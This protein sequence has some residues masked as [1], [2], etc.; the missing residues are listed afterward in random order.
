MNKLFRRGLMLAAAIFSFGIATAQLPQQMPALPVDTAVHVGKLDNGL[1][2][3]IR[4]NNTPKGQVD[5]FIAQKV[6]SILEE[7]NQRGLA[8]FL[9]HMC[10]NGSEN[11]PGNS[12]INWLESVGVKFGHNLNAYTDVDE[13][14]YRI[15]NVPAS[16]K[17]VIDSCLLVLH[18]W[19]CALT[20]DPKEIDS[21]RKVI[22]EEWRQAM[23]GEMRVIEKLLPTIYPDN[24][25][26]ERLP[27]GTMG[28]VDNFPYQAL[29]DYYHTWYRPDQQ[30]IIVVGDIDPTYVEAKIK[31]Y[32][33]PIKMPENAKE[34]VYVPVDDNPG[35]IYAV[36]S[37]PEVRSAEFSISFKTDPMLPKE[38]RNTQAFFPVEYMKS[39]VS[40]ML[41]SRL[42]EL[43]KSPDC[44]FARASVSLGK[45]FISTTK[46][47]LAIDGTAKGNDIIPAVKSI[48]REV[49]RAVRG[50]FTVGEYERARAEFLSRYERLYENRNN[51][52][53][54]TYGKEYVRSFIDNDPI[55]GIA[56]EYEMYKQIAPMIPIEAINQLLPQ[57]VTEDNR[58]FMA[59]LPE[60]DKQIIPTEDQLEAA[61][62]SVDDEEIEPYKDEMKAEPLIPS[63]PAPGKVVS[64]KELKQWDATE[65]TL[66]NGV[67]VIVKP[68]KFKDNEIVFN[69]Y[70]NGGTSVVSDDKA[71]TVKFLPYAMNQHG[72]GDYTATDVQKYL[73]GKQVSM[74]MS[75]NDYY[76]LVTGETT[77][78]DL[79]TLMELIYMGFS[80]F[81]ITPDEFAA[82]QNM[83]KGVIGNQESTPNFIFA[84]KFLD[85][86][87]KSDKKKMIS[88]AD[89]E[90]A[91]RQQTLDIVHTMLADASDYT[92][93]FTGNI[94]LETFRP[95]VEQYIATLP[96]GQKTNL[97]NVKYD[98]ALEPVIGSGTDQFTTAMETPQTFVFVGVYG[99]IPYDHRNKVLASIA[100]QILSNRLLKKVR[101]EMGAVYS[102]GMQGDMDRFGNVNT[103]L[104]TAFPMK[105][106]MKDETLAVI[107]DLIT[108]MTEN[109]TDDELNPIKEYMA[110]EATS[111]LEING[112]WAGS[113]AGWSSNGVDTF[114]GRAEL[115]NSLTTKDVQNFMR[116]LI[117]QNN[118]RVVVLDPEAK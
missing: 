118:Y 32:F 87:F 75:F 1:T 70:A 42:S 113:I 58:V 55:P 111:N 112:A 88:S 67:K 24:R 30:G 80:A 35:T 60:N 97:D 79:P 7:E 83:I 44:D 102:I 92:F 59:F 12:L 6:G 22:H 8:H 41:Q 20:L 33:A 100:G 95:L 98:P 103:I 109:V 9:E 50:G 84:K 51:T 108:S 47:A 45:F 31:E 104:Q 53:S 18:D 17:E 4:H 16:R 15:N 65:W 3:Y 14:V 39:M 106:E 99:N 110:K 77:V 64:T 28:V 90:A 52:E 78:K 54:T 46:D 74:N 29:I 43:A 62:A 13:T 2:Y 27:I 76:R 117:D 5:F 85:T 86:L 72:L 63:L 105:P 93:V 82:S 36:G 89:I 114:N 94:D 23:V 49:L 115:I 81:E 96:A 11:F 57:L 101:E 25:Y 38:Y 26:G 73:Q 68:T 40:S 91:D 19:A 21:E 10:F 107:H 66:S 34:R 69:A 61:I 116:K 48:Y 71:S 37:D 56:V